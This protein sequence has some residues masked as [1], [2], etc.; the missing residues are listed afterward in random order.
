MTESNA[1]F[2]LS[3]HHTGTW[4]VID[5]LR[6][7][8]DAGP[9]IEFRELVSSRDTDQAKQSFNAATKP[10]IIQTHYVGTNITPCLHFEGNGVWQRMKGHICHAMLANMKTV[11]P[12]RDPVLSILTRAARHPE[13]DPAYFP[14]AFEELLSI[15]NENVLFLPIDLDW[16]TER[17]HAELIAMFS[18][19]GLDPTNRHVLEYAA[20]WE[21][22]SYN[23]SNPTPIKSAYAKRDAD[24][25]M[26][27]QTIYPKAVNELYGRRARLQELL[28]GLGYSD[29]LW[30]E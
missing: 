7:H 11:I 30:W 6:N 22:P 21:A 1:I 25:L 20:K 8:P 24:A 4:F 5:A 23:I 3:V 14:L 27:L 19:V 26:H 10:T 28:E 12:V 29:L 2:V 16:D 13:Q 9:F 17:R 15:Q 18:H